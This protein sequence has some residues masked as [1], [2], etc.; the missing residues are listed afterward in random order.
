M[1]ITYRG[2]ASSALKQNP[3]RLLYTGIQKKKAHKKKLSAASRQRRGV[4][5]IPKRKYKK[6]K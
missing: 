2:E 4:S 5:P 1:Y 6:G 3:F